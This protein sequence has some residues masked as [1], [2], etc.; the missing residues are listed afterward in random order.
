[1]TTI[2]ETKVSNLDRDQPFAFRCDSGLSCFTDCCRQL[3]LALTPYDVLRLSTHLGLSGGDF[4]ERYALIE[5]NDQDAFPQVFLGMVDDGRS[6]CPFV[7]AAGC[8]VYPSRPGA[9]RTYPLGRGARLAPDNRCDDFYVLVTE[10]HCRG[11]AGKHSQTVTA[12]LADQ[13]LAPYNAFNDLTMQILQHPQIRQGF[14]P[15]AEQQA[16]Y[17]EILYRLTGFTTAPAASGDERL[18]QGLTRLS[19]ELF[20]V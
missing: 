8:T 6:S 9:C 5:K 3:E 2:P 15:D 20:P 7:S 18:R 1:M 12:W 4:L 17:L 11:F 13:E 16:R 10:P 14:R 19:D